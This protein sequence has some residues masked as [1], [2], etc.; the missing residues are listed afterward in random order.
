MMQ[1]DAVARRR[2]QIETG[3]IGSMT[4]VEYMSYVLGLEDLEN[5][6]QV[7]MQELGH[8]YHLIGDYVARGE[9]VAA[10]EATRLAFMQGATFAVCVMDYKADKA[11]KAKRATVTD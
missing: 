5:V 9:D 1:P 8:V 10:P 3:H 4:W 2:E 11:E 7:C 6:A